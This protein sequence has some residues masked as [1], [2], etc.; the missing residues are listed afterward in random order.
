MNNE[1][2]NEEVKFAVKILF[3]L[4]I[5]TKLV[6]THFMNEY[7]I[8]DELQNHRNKYHRNIIAIYES[9]VDKPS[10]AFFA[11]FPKDLKRHVRHVNGEKRSN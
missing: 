8:N 11:H 1:G 4:G 9:F 5:E 3:N 6:A 10:D 7:A 2:G